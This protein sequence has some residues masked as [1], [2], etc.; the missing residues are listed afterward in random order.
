MVGNRAAV[1]AIAMIRSETHT[2]V[3]FS[4]NKARTA[5][6]VNHLQICTD[7]VVNVGFMRHTHTR[8]TSTVQKLG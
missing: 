6:G 3:V 8:V 1:C 7:D 5:N 4:S 2:S